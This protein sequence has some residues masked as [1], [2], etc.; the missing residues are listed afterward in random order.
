M[1]AIYSSHLLQCMWY[2]GLDIIGMLLIH[3]LVIGSSLNMVHLCIWFLSEPWNSLLVPL[4]IRDSSM[5]WSPNSSL[6][7]IPTYLQYTWHMDA[8]NKCNTHLKP[9][10]LI[11]ITGSSLN[12]KSSMNIANKRAQQWFLS[13]PNII[14]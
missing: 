13:K 14:T 4:W 3:P 2:Q 7:R 9:P 10:N 12:L 6:D 1:Y 5:D 8:T 11:L